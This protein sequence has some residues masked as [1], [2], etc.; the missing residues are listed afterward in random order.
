M[1]RVFAA[2]AGFSTTCLK[3]GVCQSEI[4]VLFLQKLSC[5]HFGPRSKNIMPC[6]CKRKKQN[7]PQNCS[8]IPI[9]FN[10]HELKKYLKICDP[11]GNCICLLKDPTCAHVSLIFQG[12]SFTHYLG[13][14]SDI[15][16]CE[17]NR[18]EYFIGVC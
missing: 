2:C 17:C 4:S 12:S 14:L 6:S 8:Y 3:T 16:K 15:S 1:L 5:V 11:H 10:L 18:N 13:F 9:K 7:P